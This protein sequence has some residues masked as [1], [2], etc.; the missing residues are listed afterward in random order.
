MN[1]MTIFGMSRFRKAHTL[2]KIK[3]MKFNEKLFI[4]NKKTGFT[5]LLTNTADSIKNMTE[6]SLRI[7]LLLISFVFVIRL[8]LDGIKYG[9]EE[10]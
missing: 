1:S 4:S 2:L 8:V 3:Y 9:Y 7:Q 6:R 5:K 10:K